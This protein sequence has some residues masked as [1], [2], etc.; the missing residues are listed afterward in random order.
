MSPIPPP[1]KDKFSRRAHKCVFIGYTTGQKAFK[2]YDLLSHKI[3]I[4]RDIKFFETKFPFASDTDYLIS[5]SPTLPLVSLDSPFNHYV[6][7]ST[8]NSSA[9]NTITSYLIP[10]ID[11][12]S[13]T[14]SVP[15]PLPITAP[16]IPRTSTRQ[17]KPPSWLFDYVCNVSIHCPTISNFSSDYTAFVADVSKI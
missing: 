12:V 1:H 13:S 7:D 16:I 10:S 8:N 5:Q 3:H 14:S 2:A 15:P 4:T 9:A 17:S 11:E 6:L